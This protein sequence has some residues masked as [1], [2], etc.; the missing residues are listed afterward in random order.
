MELPDLGW[1]GG[2]IMVTRDKFDE[3]IEWYTRHMG[4]TST[5]TFLS[6]VGKMA[7]LHHPI[8]DHFSQ[9]V[10]K[11][12]ESDYEHFQFDHQNEGH[13][14]LC[15]SMADP[16]KTFRYFQDHEIE[17]SDRRTLPDGREAFDM[18]GFEGAILTAVHDPALDGQ[19]PDARLIGFGP[20]TQIIGVSDIKRSVKWYEKYL[21]YKL[22]DENTD[23]GYAWMEALDGFLK[24]TQGKITKIPVLLEHV[25]EQYQ[26]RKANPAARGY[27]FL[28]LG[29]TFIST[30][31][32][33][34]AEGI[35]TSEIAGDPFSWGAFHFYDPDGNR[36][37]VWSYN[38]EE[39]GLV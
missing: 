36:I 32:Q 1:D 31:R 15:F 22:V 33:L 7:F 28:P 11:T 4:W 6:N 26:F 2:F 25:Q 37:N 24:N 29:E 3:G 14:R 35:E 13:T 27:H 8:R 38:V 39:T 19:Y 12:F 9:V 30:R 21:G 17:V 34:E 23:H 5:D 16:E 10:L 20:I 18:I